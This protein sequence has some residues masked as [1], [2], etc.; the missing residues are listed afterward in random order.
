MNFYRL[1]RI[2]LQNP[3]AV[4]KSPMHIVA[5]SVPIVLGFTTPLSHSPSI[6]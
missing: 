4:V 5:N 3:V 2:V 6:A 1:V